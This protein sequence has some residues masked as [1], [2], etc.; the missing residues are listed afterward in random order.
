M[1]VDLVGGG[2][3]IGT[4]DTHPLDYCQNMPSTGRAASEENQ[5]RANRPPPP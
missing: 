4:T 3:L 1:H 5:L 2:E